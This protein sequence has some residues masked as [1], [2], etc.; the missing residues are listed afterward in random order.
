MAQANDNVG[1]RIPLIRVVEEKE[2][3]GSHS[4]FVFGGEAKVR[5]EKWTSKPGATGESGVVTYI[6]T[7]TME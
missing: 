2:I 5:K 6:I 1:L 3:L 7:R 4:I